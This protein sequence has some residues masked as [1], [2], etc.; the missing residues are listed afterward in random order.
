[1]K[2]KPSWEDKIAKI[3]GVKL[4][5]VHETQ[6]SYTGKERKTIIVKRANGSKKAKAVREVLDFIRTNFIS[7]EDI[8]K[9][10]EESRPMIKT[11]ATQGKMKSWKLE[12]F[13]GKQDAIDEYR[14]AILQ[15]LKELMK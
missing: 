5:L 13:I 11:R 1:M 9:V 14:E 10:I 8:E 12:Y 15:R 4:N 3:L 7:R 2:T 6:L